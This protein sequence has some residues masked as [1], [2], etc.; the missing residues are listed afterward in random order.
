MNSFTSHVVIVQHVL[1]RK[2]VILPITSTKRRFCLCNSEF[3]NKIFLHFS[4]WCSA[5]HLLS[6][7]GKVFFS[8]VLI[9]A[10]WSPF[11]NAQ[12]NTALASLESCFVLEK[13]CQDLLPLKKSSFFTD[14][15]TMIL[16]P[17]PSPSPRL[18]GKWIPIYRRRTGTDK[19]ILSV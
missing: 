4:Y 2:T 11:S 17:L 19:D 8:M 9:E 18:K 1:S 16:A 14:H 15:T 13:G 12:V 3:W 5:S 7:A 10:I 6:L